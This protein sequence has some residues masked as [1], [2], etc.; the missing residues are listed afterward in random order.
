M[1]DRA[2][3]RR[4]LPPK[5]AKLTQCRRLRGIVERKLEALWSPE[6]ISAWLASQHP[7]RPE[8]YVSHQ[9]IYQ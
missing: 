8:M 7:D 9:T 2:A 3:C 4:A 6:Q 5:R 1:A